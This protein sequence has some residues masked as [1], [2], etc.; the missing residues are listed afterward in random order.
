MRTFCVCL[1][2]VSL[3]I[4]RPTVVS[5]DYYDRLAASHKGDDITAFRDFISIAENGHV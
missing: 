5:A 1:L 2:L 3:S 4:L